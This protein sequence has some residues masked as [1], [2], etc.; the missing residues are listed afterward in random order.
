MRTNP[1]DPQSSKVSRDCLPHYHAQG[2]LG[3]SVLEEGVKLLGSE[4]LGDLAHHG[5]L[6]NIRGVVGADS[7]A[8]EAAGFLGGYT[9]RESKVVWRGV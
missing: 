2:S 5:P 8:M 7:R 9:H 3:R 6:M 4:E 1:I